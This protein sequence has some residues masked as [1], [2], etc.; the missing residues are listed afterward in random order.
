MDQEAIR[1][2][3]ERAGQDDA[4]AQRAA[5]KRHVARARTCSVQNLAEALR[6]LLVSTNPSRG[7][8]QPPNL[9]RGL[10]CRPT[11]AD[12]QQQLR[13]YRGGPTSVSI[14]PTFPRVQNQDLKNNHFLADQSLIGTIQVISPQRS[15]LE[16]CHPRPLAS[17]RKNLTAKR[18][19]SKWHF[20]I[21]AH[22]AKKRNLTHETRLPQ[23]VPGTCVLLYP[24]ARNH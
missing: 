11:E 9:L 1:G 2:L 17:A 15:F 13:T 12:V 10:F 23:N 18:F 6:A 22:T 19:P 7:S 5:Q 20:V 4:T 16:P 24:G 14:F 21:W 3:S 8:P